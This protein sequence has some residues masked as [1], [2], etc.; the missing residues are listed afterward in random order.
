MRGR[1]NLPA[2]M[3]RLSRPMTTRF[4]PEWLSVAPARRRMRRAA[5]SLAAALLAPPLSRH[6]TRGFMAF[7]ALSCLIFL[8]DALLS[9]DRGLLGQYFPNMEWKGTPA[10]TTLDQHFSLMRQQE[11][12]PEWHAQFGILWT[13]VIYIPAAGEYQFVTASD[14]GSCIFIDG[15]KFLNNEGMHPY[16]RLAASISLDKGFHPIGIRYVQGGGSA[17]LEVSWIPPHGAEEPIPPA[18]VFPQEPTRWR[19]AVERLLNALTR[20]LIFLW[21]GVGLAGCGLG[22]GGRRV[23]L[24]AFQASA[25]GRQAQ[26]LKPWCCAEDAEQP[27]WTLIPP[28]ARPF[29]AGLIALLLA[30]F[31]LNLCGI[32]WGLPSFFGWAMDE[33]I[34]RMVKGAIAVGFAH[35]WHDY[36]PP[37]HYYLLAAVHAPFYL[38]HHLN[39]L[40]IESLASYTLLFY[41]GRL[42]SA[43]MG[44]T[45]VFVVYLCGCELLDRRAALFAAAAMAFVPEFVYYAKITNVDVPY[46]FWFGLSLFCYIRILAYHRF[47][48]YALFAATAALAVCTKDQAYGLYAFA[49]V[50]I[51]ISYHRYR[52]ERDPA[53]S[54]F[55]SLFN[56]KTLTALGIG[57][58]MFALAQNFLFDWRGFVEHV[59]LITGPGNEEQLYRK[60][61]LGYEAMLWQSLKNIRFAFGWPMFLACVAG[62]AAELFRRPRHWRLWATLVPGV[63]YYVTFIC[64]IMYDYDRFLLPVCL[65][66]TFF[67]GKWLAEQ[68]QSRAWTRL[69]RGVV[70]AVLAY[71]AAYA[72][73][74]DILMLRDSRYHVEAWMREHLDAQASIG[75]LGLTEFLPRMDRFDKT[76]YLAWPTVNDVKIVAPD[77]FVVNRSIEYVGAAAQTWNDVY[78]GLDGGAFGY[79]LLFEYQTDE[80]LP[81]SRRS[82]FKNGKREVFT[83]IDKINP[84]IQ[85]FRK[86]R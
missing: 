82:I 68:W 33:V 4:F 79:E 12:L 8:A 47:A 60:T 20:L 23:L 86:K 26:R 17:A 65:L 11:K 58:L 41:A 70:C 46:L 7:L 45:L 50:P 55:A 13:G 61:V 16:R 78:A 67:A 10:L 66:L 48:D 28:N 49:A 64:V 5:E 69:K 32:S 52:Q 56:R 25:W 63:S 71:S 29:S 36:Y 57:V 81:L 27:R 39:A 14:D 51:L 9:H 76:F 73:S 1:G 2:Q 30:S 54:L 6:F 84:R 80:W 43:V 44:T 22:V 31:G 37:V 53:A 3:N 62:M 40:N 35:G 24:P 59:K 19:F 74:V 38:L 15:K 85:I 72:L 21:I 34:P 77:Y 75:M 83:N 18:L 42:L